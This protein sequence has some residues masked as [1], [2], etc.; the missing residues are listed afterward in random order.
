MDYLPPRPRL[1][2]GLGACLGV[3]CGISVLAFSSFDLNV[4][5]AL[6]SFGSTSVLL[7]VF[8]ENHFSQPRSIVGGHVVSTTLGLLAL[9]LFGKTWW[10]LGLAVAVST[11]VM[12]LT[13]TMHPPAGSNPIIVFLTAS[14]WSF[15]LFPTLFG[16]LALVATGWCYHRLRRQIYPSY[17]L[18]T[19]LREKTLLRHSRTQPDT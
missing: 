18:G 16:A 17:W 6:G 3:F 10:S 8:P 15:A 7:F 11:A 2:V 13:R 5:L 4:L 14:G 1:H 9:A 19:D 12:M